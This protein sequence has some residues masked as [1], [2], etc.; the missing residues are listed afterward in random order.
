MDLPE[1]L[2]LLTRIV[3]RVHVLDAPRTNAVSVASAGLRARIP[4]KM[5]R[6]ER[7]REHRDHEQ[8][9]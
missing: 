9:Q 2:S 6:H 8:G 3:L 7:P 5:P 4:Q 1:G